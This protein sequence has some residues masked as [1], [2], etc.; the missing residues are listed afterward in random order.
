MDRL[1]QLFNVSSHEELF[2][3]MKEHPEDP[4]VQELKELIEEINRPKTGEKEE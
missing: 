2:Q 3:Y 4:K 1:F